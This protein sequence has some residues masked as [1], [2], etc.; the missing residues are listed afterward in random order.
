MPKAKKPAKK[1]VRKCFRVRHENDWNRRG[2][3]IEPLGP[4]GVETFQHDN[5]A[6]WILVREV[7]PRRKRAKGGGE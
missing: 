3:Q 2:W 5:D 6:G 7:L 4:V 1:L